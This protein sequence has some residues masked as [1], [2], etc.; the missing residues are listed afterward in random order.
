MSTIS[1]KSGQQSEVLLLGFYRQRLHEITDLIA[2]SHHL[3]SPI[4][5]IS[6]GS[7]SSTNHSPTTHAT[8]ALT[9]SDSNCFPTDGRKNSY[10]KP[11]TLNHSL[12]P[13]W[14][15]AT[16]IKS[17]ESLE[18]ATNKEITKA[19]TG[20][21]RSSGSSASG[22]VS[23]I[24]KL[25]RTGSSKKLAGS[26]KAIAMLESLLPSLR[27]TGSFFGFEVSDHFCI[28]YVYPRLQ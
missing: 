15:L 24:K 8:T 14:D 4:K 27:T 5:T 26:S 6:S 1:L 21:K 12:S 23:W 9:D 3:S 20:T 25:A 19:E 13:E 17:T 10:G 16:L 22:L 28:R 7:S 2:Q 18:I 11:S